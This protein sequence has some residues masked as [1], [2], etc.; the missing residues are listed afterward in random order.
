MKNFFLA[1]AL[2]FF[3][4]SAFAAAPVTPTLLTG[5]ASGADLILSW[6][7]VSGATGYSVYAKGVLVATPS[8]NSV[9]LTSLVAGS[10]YS[11]TVL[12]SNSSGSS[13]QSSSYTYIQPTTSGL[14]VPTLIYAT[15]PDFSSIINALAPIASSVASVSTQVSSVI[16]AQSLSSPVSMTSS[17]V[18]ILCAGIFAFFTGFGFTKGYR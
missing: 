10:S 2:S 4:F 18:L 6:S 1:I 11:F 14:P 12:A 13:A 15:P 3:S 16:S 5:S 8:I 17:S 9:L 7:A